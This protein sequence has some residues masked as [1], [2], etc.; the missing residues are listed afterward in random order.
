MV[1]MFMPAV[2]VANAAT[3]EAD[4]TMSEFFPARDAPIYIVRSSFSMMPLT[5]ATSCPTARRNNLNPSYE[6]LCDVCRV[7]V[8][9]STGVAC[10]L[11]MQ[12]F[13][14]HPGPNIAER[15]EKRQED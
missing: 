14:G 2:A 13:Y 1:M 10:C 6:F 5:L 3:W 9:M 7:A 11:G 4:T 8:N 15:V 12:P